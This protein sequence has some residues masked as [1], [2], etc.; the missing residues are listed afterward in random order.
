MPVSP[1]SS[2]SI[3][4]WNY[5][6]APVLAP[7]PI[8]GYTG[9]RKQDGRT[10]GRTIG[11]QR[12]L[13]ASPYY[14]YK[15][16][17]AYPGQKPE[18]IWGGFSQWNTNNCTIVA[19]I[20][21]AMMQF[22]EKPT[23][24]FKEVRETPD[25]YYVTLK[26]GETIFLS[27]DELKQAAEATKL[28]CQNIQTAIYANFIVA[29]AAKRFQEQNHGSGPADY[30]RALDIM[31]DGGSIEYAFKRLGLWELVEQ[32]PPEELAE[33]RLGVFQSG[34]HVAVSVDGKEERWGKQGGPTPTGAEVYVAYGFKNDAGQ[35][36]GV[37]ASGKV[38]A[39]P[40]RH[41]SQL[42]WRARMR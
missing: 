25:G 14:Q 41:L 18:N 5:Q 22:G 3:T 2:D 1:I 27:K 28:K 31:N 17:N 33:G 13:R 9:I 7:L 29:V 26:N 38:A 16:E 23:D 34:S 40:N 6:P 35:S 8:E 19:V 37:K 39:S 36:E 42:G 32:V 20:K 11:V 4:G 10:Y 21:M 24:I 15:P 12:N 30:A